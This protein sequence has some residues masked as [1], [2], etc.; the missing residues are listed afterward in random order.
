MRR[1]LCIL[2]PC[3]GGKV[4]GG[5]L[6]LCS[7]DNSW[8]LSRAKPAIRRLKEKVEEKEAGRRSFGLGYPA[9]LD[10]LPSCERGKKKKGTP[11]ENGGVTSWPQISEPGQERGRETRW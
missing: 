11:P 8:S 5:V 7:I 6:S 9:G 3:A 4:G 1:G 2:R 10:L